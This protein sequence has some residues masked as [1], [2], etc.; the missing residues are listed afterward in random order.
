MHKAKMSK[1]RGNVADPLAAM[2]KFGADG[3][4]W[5]LMRVGGSLPKD[6]DYSEGELE[7]SYGRLQDQLG[8]LISRLGSRK[9]FANVG[10]WDDSMR[11][12]GLDATLSTLR[13]EVEARFEDCNISAACTL[14]LDMLAEINKYFTESMPWRGD[15]TA[16]VAYTYTG[17][18]MAG[19]LTSPILPNKALELF[20]RLQVPE[21]ERTWASATWAT[22]GPV[23]ALMMTERLR[24]GVQAYYGQP[25]LFPKVNDPTAQN[26]TTVQG[27]AK[28]KSRP[29]LKPNKKKVGRSTEVEESA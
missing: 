16:A 25:P 12:P 14:V 2:D 13:D 7:A 9:V 27:G 4:R 15:S 20:D 21:E 3:V 22:Q 19:I 5:Y 28:G 18:R 11:L 6:S 24:A 8:N 1:S 17:L 26:M 23:D 10:A 29:V